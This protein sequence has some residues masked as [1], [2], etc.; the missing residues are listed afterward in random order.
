[1]TGEEIYKIEQNKIKFHTRNMRKKIE[2]LEK[3]ISALDQENGRLLDKI[4]L[5]DD[6]IEN[7]EM[8]KPSSFLFE[9]NIK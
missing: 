1:M 2:I 5:L 8:R 9:N 4:I 6:R 3:R 7:L